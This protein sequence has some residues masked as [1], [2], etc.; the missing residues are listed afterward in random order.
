[1]GN[2]MLTLSNTFSSAIN[3]LAKPQTMAKQTFSTT[4]KEV[5]EDR[6]RVGGK[7]RRGRVGKQALEF[8]LYF[9]NT[10]YFGTEYWYTK[11]SKCNPK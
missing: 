8:N 10:A 7:V 3:Q 6:T 11:C 2:N 5:K 1:V 9:E 4:G